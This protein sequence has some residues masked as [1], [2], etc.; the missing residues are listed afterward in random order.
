MQPTA[1]TLQS[2]AKVATKV[3]TTQSLHI[4]TLCS[5]PCLH[6]FHHDYILSDMV[7]C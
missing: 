2:S 7:A 1:A 5:S 3:Q 4:P 6:D